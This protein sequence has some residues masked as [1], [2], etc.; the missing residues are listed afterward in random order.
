[1]EHGEDLRVDNAYLYRGAKVILFAVILFTLFL[2]ITTFLGLVPHLITINK[3][4]HGRILHS[5]GK[6]ST[7]KIYIII[8]VVFMHVHTFKNACGK[9]PPCHNNAI[10]QS[11][12]TDKGYRCL[13]YPGFTGEYCDKGKVQLDL[14]K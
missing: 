5:F 1:M 4:T 11:G 3:S 8:S 6:M 9:N 14:L 10:C 7:K 2:V 13:C 12:F